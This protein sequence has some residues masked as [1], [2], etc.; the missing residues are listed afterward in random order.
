MYVV[1]ASIQIKQGFKEPFIKTMILDAEGSTSNEPRCLRFDV[2]QDP[3]DTVRIW[4]Y[5]VWENE[6]ALQAHTQ[7]PHFKKLAETVKD[8]RCEGLAG[9][10]RGRYNIWPPGDQW[11]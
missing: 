8:W 7:R 11:K 9:A 3:V 6:D 4:P 2:I 10:S 1:I 5:E